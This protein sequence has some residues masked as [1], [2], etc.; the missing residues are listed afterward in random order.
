[1]NS[2]AGLSRC[3][4]TDRILLWGA[5]C[6]GV[7]PPAR[8]R[9]ASSACDVE[10]CTC[11][12]MLEAELPTL[13]SRAPSLDGSSPVVIYLYVEDVDATA[14]RALKRGAKFVVPLETHFWANERAGSRIPPGTCGQ[15]QRASRRQRKTND[16]IDG[17]KSC[18]RIVD[19]NLRGDVHSEGRC[20]RRGS[21]S[22]S[23][24]TS[25][26]IGSPAPYTSVSRNVARPV[27]CGISV[28]GPFGCRCL[29]SLTMLPFPHPADRTGC[30]DF[31]FPALGERLPM[32]PTGDCA[33]A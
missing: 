17:R 20:A 11:Q 15:S 29:N 28:A 27:R 14:E 2:E 23:R 31:P 6:G 5:G 13:P 3:R 9:W 18:R 30:A 10:I 24:I 21:S 7:P 4:G 12:L 19:R 16:A 32:T 26:S 33:S 1:V 22:T 8:A 25:K